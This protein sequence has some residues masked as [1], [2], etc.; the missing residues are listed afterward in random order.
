MHKNMTQLAMLAVGAVLSGAHTSAGQP[1]EPIFDGA[2][3][4]SSPPVAAQSRG[5]SAAER[6]RRDLLISERTLARIDR[7]LAELRRGRNPDPLVIADYETYRDLVHT[8]TERAR[9]IAAELGAI[10]AVSVEEVEPWL[11]VE[12]ALYEPEIDPFE[13]E[14]DRL[15]REFRRSLEAFDAYLLEEQFEARR[16]AD[17]RDAVSSEGMTDLAR[18]A[19]AAVERLRNQGIDVDTSAPPGQG[20]SPGD[21]GGDGVEGD[22]GGAAGDQT[23]G[24]PGGQA[25]E[26]AGSG[27]GENQSG[28]PESGVPGAGQPGGLPGGQAGGQ[29]GDQAGGQAGGQ[30]SAGQP[31]AGSS[32]GG[33][34]SGGGSSTTGDSSGGSG[35]TENPD[36]SESEE[37]EG[38]GGSRDGGGP[39]PSDD[40]DIVARQ[41]RE[42]AE[43]ETDPEMRE[44]LWEEYE[45]YKGRR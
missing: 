20:G 27:A 16:R 18:E 19:A 12:P 6:A 25:G 34:H 21:P 37:V 8:M 13:S 43:R 31:G 1:A 42:A 2:V 44:K 38:E 45:R 41:L 14:A 5:L 28:Q 10:E 39:P 4:A 36:G 23:Q 7:D 26:G 29:A 40:D 3:R 22:G 15:D 24:G 32:S 30:G 33:E 11:L 9:R 35:D 17:E